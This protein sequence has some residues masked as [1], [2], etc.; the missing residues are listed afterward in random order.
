MPIDLRLDPSE[1]ALFTDLYE[2]TVSAAFFE[3]GFNDP[4]SF[5]VVDAPDA[6]GPRFHDRRRNRAADRGARGIPLRRRRDRASR[7]AAPLQAGV[8]RIPRATSASPASIRALPEGTI[9]FAGEPIV[10]IRAPLI[11]AQLIE[12]LAL[13]QLGF[14]SIAATKAARCFAVAGGRRLVDFGPRRAQGTDASLIAARSSYLAGFHGTANV[15]AGKRYGI[16]VFGTMSHSF[17]MAHE[18]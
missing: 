15:L 4:A 16:P 10:E 17:V 7:I 2:L 8:S 11:E 6:A 12:T 3:H 9:Y 1:V 5:E 18:Q 14:A 13:N